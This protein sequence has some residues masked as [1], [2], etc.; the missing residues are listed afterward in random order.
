MEYVLALPIIGFFLYSVLSYYMADKKYNFIRNLI[1]LGV[2]TAGYVGLSFVVSHPA[3][4]YLPLIQLGA[5]GLLFVMMVGALGKKVSGASILSVTA[6]IALSPAFMLPW[7][8]VGGIVCIILASIITSANRMKLVKSMMAELAYN[9]S[10]QSFD[11]GYLPEHQ[12]TITGASR[13]H[14]VPLYALIGVCLSIL[15]QI[16]FAQVF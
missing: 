10:V 16:L 4:W 12:D 3:A 5:A 6:L 11:Y 15:A 8:L 14:F 13:T 1:M 7:T 9:P 2:L